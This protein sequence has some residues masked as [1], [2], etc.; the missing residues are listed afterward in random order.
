MYIPSFLQ[1]SF[2]QKKVAVPAPTLGE[3]NREGQEFPG[4]GNNWSHLRLSATVRGCVH[5][6]RRAIELL[7]T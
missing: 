7:C 4:G 1:Y 3:G 6:T 5:G 2:G